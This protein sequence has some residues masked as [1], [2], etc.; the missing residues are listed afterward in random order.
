MTRTGDTYPSL[1]DRVDFTQANYGEIF[2]SV[3][4]NSL[5]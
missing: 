2:V 4:V 5:C 1:Q 3:H